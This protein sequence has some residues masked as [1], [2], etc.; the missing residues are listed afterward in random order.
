V[1]KTFAKKQ[2][3]IAL[4]QV[5]IISIILMMLAIYIIQTARM[6]I[7]TTHL[8]QKSF[9][10]N[11]AGESAEAELL[12][13]LLTNKR[14]QNK[15]SDNKLVQN[16]NFY[17]QPFSYDENTEI[18]IQDVSSLLSLNNTN[19]ILSTRLFEQLGYQEKDS[20]TFFDSL[21]DWKDKDDLKRL[22]GAEKD[23][24]HSA[25]IQGPRNGYLQSMNEVLNIK[26]SDILTTEEWHN[27]FTIELTSEFNP[28][29][30]PDDI[31]KAFLNDEQA[32][33]DV[34]NLRDQG[35]LST[36]NFYQATGIDSD[37]RITFNTGRILQIKIITYK[38]NSQFIKSFI[39][40]LRPNSYMRT[41]T[42]SNVRWD[43]E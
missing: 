1:K 14:Y 30:A 33:I 6:Q 12:H 36:Y 13:T 24:Y 2:S 21:S 17:G 9:Q 18:T 32:F 11:L 38:Q 29:N 16:W 22:N 27:Y 15:N 39:V 40:D 3:G 37:E 35:V 26:G 8:M 10:V 25:N 20:R 5:L 42:I 23:Y 34:I 7:K 4:V 19:K 31:L 28:L 43:N 41:V